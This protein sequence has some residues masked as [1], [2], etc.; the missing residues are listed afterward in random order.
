[1]WR[2]A[3]PYV[4]IGAAAVLYLVGR[5]LNREGQRMTGREAPRFVLPVIG[6]PDKAVDS[7][8]LRGRPVAL[9][10][11][12]NRGDRIND[13]LRFWQDMH[14]QYGKQGLLVLGISMED[15]PQAALAHLNKLGVTFPQVDA[16]AQ[17]AATGASGVKA[18]QEGVPGVP[19]AFVLDR[20]SWIRLHHIGWMDGSAKTCREWVERVLAEPVAS[21]PTTQPAVASQPSAD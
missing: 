17:I 5:Y 2:Q 19:T 18:Y 14:T 13:A 10:F 6:Q 12:Q 15:N 4:V 9:V 11:W 20:E 8:D 7:A 16:V 21:Q 1:M 3:G